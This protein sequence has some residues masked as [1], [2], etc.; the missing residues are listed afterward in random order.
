MNLAGFLIF[1]KV[2]TSRHVK[3]CLTLKEREF[4]ITLMEAFSA[5]GGTMGDYY[6]Y[7]WKA[8]WIEALGILFLGLFITIRY[9]WKVYSKAQ[10]GIRFTD[11]LLLFIRGLGWL[12]VYFAYL[13][14]FNAS[15]PDWFA[16][17][18]HVQG[19]IQGKS[20]VPN[21]LHPYSVEVEWESGR[22][23]L[24]LDHYTYEE[25]DPGQRVNV[26]FLPHRLQVI[27]CEI[28]PPDK[29]R[30]E[31]DVAAELNQKNGEEI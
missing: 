26:T 2:I 3:Y 23:T 12:S 21:S 9:V 11:K 29:D 24:L 31:D 18:V 28:L 27:S 1:K 16:K 19:E 15:E 7:L 6:Q 30:N 17:P 25:L 14:M 5:M 13:L 10:K 20:M 8:T 4:I 22:E